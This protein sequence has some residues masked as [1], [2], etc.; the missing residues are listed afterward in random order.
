[1]GVR[2]GNK[3]RVWGTGRV[4]REE[5]REC[6]WSCSVEVERC[7]GP[8]DRWGN[9]C[10]ERDTW[11]SLDRLFFDKKGV[12]WV[13]SNRQIVGGISGIWRLRI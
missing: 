6:G 2:I 7:W 12:T 13:V 10:I 5:L 3:A 1:M 8:L 11:G 9:N 4:R